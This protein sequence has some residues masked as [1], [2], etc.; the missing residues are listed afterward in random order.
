MIEGFDASSV[1]R[2]SNQ[3]VIRLL[4]QYFDALL[5][6]RKYGGSL[7]AHM[8]GPIA[9]AWYSC[10]HDRLAKFATILKSGTS[11]CEE[12][13]AA[14][15]LAFAHASEKI[16]TAGERSLWYRKTEYALSHF[17]RGKSIMTLREATK[18]LYEIPEEEK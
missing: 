6:C 8:Q 11:T 1:N 7:R 9:R 18:E 16:S 13:Q 14:A 12:D 4:V 15:K 2:V 5:F 10:D 17:M 3:R